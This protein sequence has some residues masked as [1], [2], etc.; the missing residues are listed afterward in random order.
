MEFD[1]SSHGIARAARRGFKSCLIDLGGRKLLTLG[2]PGH[3]ARGRN[4]N[5]QCL[6]ESRVHSVRSLF[7]VELATTANIEEDGSATQLASF[8]PRLS[9]AE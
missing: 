7:L 5:A 3:R 9:E 8:S 1:D 2:V 4:S 6:E